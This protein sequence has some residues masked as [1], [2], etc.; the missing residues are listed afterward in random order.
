MKTKVKVSVS[1]FNKG[2]HFSNSFETAVK[3]PQSLFDNAIADA[4]VWAK[5]HGGQVTITRKVDS[6]YINYLEVNQYNNV[7]RFYT[8][9]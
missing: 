5:M 2:K 7:E 6:L 8:T 9:L 1:Y 3:D 4:N